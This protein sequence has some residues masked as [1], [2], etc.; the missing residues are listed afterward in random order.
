LPLHPSCREAFGQGVVSAT[1]PRLNQVRDEQDI[2]H[3]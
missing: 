3:S 1:E 2:L